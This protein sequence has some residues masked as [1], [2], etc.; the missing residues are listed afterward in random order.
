MTDRRVVVTG[1]GCV[2]PLGLNVQSTWDACI[3]GK[4][5]VAPITKFD[6]S[7]YKTRIAAEVK[8]FD[9]LAYMEKK[10]SRKMGT[11]IQYAVA[12]AKM[13]LRVT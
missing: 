4:S 11:F 2:S 3:N 12:S 10:E 6:A 1:L 7:G 9:P 13:A 5:G 8:G